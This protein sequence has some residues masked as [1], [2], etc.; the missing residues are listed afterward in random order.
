[1]PIE[2]KLEDDHLALFHITG[3]LGKKEFYQIQSELES[4]IHKLG[5]IKILVILKDFTGW[6]SAEGWED[7]SFTDRND[8][9]IKKMAIVGEEKWRDFATVF[10]LKGLRP[11]PIEYFESNELDK[12]RQWLD[13]N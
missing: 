6:E 13:N 1:M 9:S 12:A 5:Y 8:E 11:V 2:F 10:T 3:E 7:T 4:I